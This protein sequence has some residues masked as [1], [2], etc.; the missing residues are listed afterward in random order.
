M[1]LA[2]IGY[3]KMGQ[4]IATQALA[5]GHEVGLTLNSTNVPAAIDEL[6]SLITGHDVAIDFSVG[7]SVLSH[8][9]ACARAGV[10]LVEGTTGWNTQLNEAR[11]L[12]GEHDAAL[13]FGANFSIGVNVYY[14]LVEKAAALFQPFEDY[15]VFIEEAHHAR[16][17]D[18][19]SG[20]ALR[21]KEIVN[22]FKQRDISIASTRAGFIPGTHTAGFDSAADQITLTHT[23]RNRDGFATGALTAARWIVGQ[24]G[25]YEFSEVVDEMLKTPVR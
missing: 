13:V 12:I 22:R 15:D 23:A 18:A 25:V 1:K 7:D 14:R 6:A 20:T 17:K 5:A 2:L 10:P 11:R 8:V 9:E 4:L 24:K 16:K 19:P 3:G 21:I